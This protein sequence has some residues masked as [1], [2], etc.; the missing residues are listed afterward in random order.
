MNR[1]FIQP[2]RPLTLASASPRRK[3]LLE[4]AGIPYEAVPS[5]IAE[6][7]DGDDPVEVACGLALQKAGAVRQ[8]SAGKWIVGA[9]TVV[10]L[11]GAV[12]GK[13]ADRAEAREML[14]KLSGREHRVT[15]G[16]S[17]LD[18]RGEEALTE[19]V[20]TGVL[21]KELDPKEI[22][23]YLDTGE[24]FGKAGGYAI[25]GVGAFMVERIDGSYTNVVGL[26]LCALIRALAFV[27]ALERYPAGWQRRTSSGG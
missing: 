23:G 19:A 22:D 25:Q 7:A 15:T 27:G 13:P 12:L 20:V 4:Q 11:E 5:E 8:A 6:H 2:D 18:P 1:H 24:P 21:F 10:V 9:D 3:R 14:E 26:P 17:I 16:F